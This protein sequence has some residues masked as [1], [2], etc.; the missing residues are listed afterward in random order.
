MNTHQLWHSLTNDFGIF[1]FSF[2]VNLG[3]RPSDWP[4]TP[5]PVTC[6]GHTRHTFTPYRQTAPSSSSAYRFILS[7]QLLSPPINHSL[8]YFSIVDGG[9]TWLI[10][11]G[12]ILNGCRVPR[13][14][15]YTNSV[16][17]S[18]ALPW[19]VIKNGCNVNS[20]LY[21]TPR[22][23]LIACWQFI[24]LIINNSLNSG[25][26]WGHLKIQFPV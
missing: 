2:F 9:C 23:Y 6:T 20:L 5:P 3:R 4:T 18:A 7:S 8:L 10:L 26:L 13:D 17:S 25:T 24:W 16:F 21:T 22:L 11:I 15:P 14:S 1:L 19:S 12:W